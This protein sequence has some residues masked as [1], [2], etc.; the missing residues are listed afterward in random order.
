MIIMNPVNEKLKFNIF[1]GFHSAK[2]KEKAT[3]RKMPFI[4]LKFYKKEKT[5]AKNYYV[6][7]TNP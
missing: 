6:N 3:K 4:S 7:T 2:V 5:K 1:N